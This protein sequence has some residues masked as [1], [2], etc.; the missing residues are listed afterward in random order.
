[1]NCNLCSLA[2]NVSIIER[3]RIIHE[4]N[5]TVD[6]Q[7]WNLIQFQKAVQ[8]PNFLR[9]EVDNSASGLSLPVFDQKPVQR[10]LRLPTF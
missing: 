7:T 4:K 9:S 6:T 8:C 10:D 5:Y 2:G 3:A 1:M